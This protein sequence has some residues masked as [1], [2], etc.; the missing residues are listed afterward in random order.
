MRKII[1]IQFLLMLV[2]GGQA[3]AAASADPDAP[4]YTAVGPIHVQIST[5]NCG[6]RNIS[7]SASLQHF[8]PEKTAR[9]T[10]FIPK[11]NSLLFLYISDYAA[12]RAGKEINN[13]SILKII[14]GT[15]DKVLGK[16][17]VSEA[18]ISSVMQN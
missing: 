2:F 7:V 1:A 8:G 5:K 14:Q 6:L 11:I 13:H 4:I 17:Y 16:G 15:A 10:G 3:N 18:L 9:I 12:K